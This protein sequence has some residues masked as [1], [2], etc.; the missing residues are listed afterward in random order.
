[1]DILSYINRINQLYGSES[2]VASGKG[3]GSVIP[4]EFDE[5]SPREEQYYQQGPFS[6]RED[7]LAAKGGS[8]Y[9]TRKYFKPGGLVEP[10]V[11]HYG[12]LVQ[13]GPGRQGYNGVKP[14]DISRPQNKPALMSDDL[15]TWYEKN[16]GKILKDA[17]GN[18]KPARAW[19]DL[20][21]NERMSVKS[22]F[23]KRNRPFYVNLRK[24][25]TLKD[26]LQEQKDAGRTVF[27]KTLPEIAKEA[28]LTLKGHQVRNIIK[29]YFPDTFN[30]KG[31][32]LDQAP[33]VLKRVKELAKTDTA[34]EITNILFDEG[35]AVSKN[36]VSVRQLMKDNKI[37][38][39]T[40][41]Q[42]IDDL[43]KTYVKNNPKITD[44]NEIAENLS[45]QVGK[46]I[47][48]TTV[49]LA[50]KRQNIKNLTS[51]QEVI[52]KEV[53]VLDN[54][55][56]NSL[57][58]INDPNMTPTA[59]NSI[60]QQ[61]YLKATGKK[62][63]DL[64]S[65]EFG[66]RLSRL[67]KLYAGEGR[68][69]AFKNIKSPLNYLDLS[70]PLQKN[71]I[72]MASKAKWM[73]NFTM[74]QMLGLPKNQLKLIADTQKMMGA[75]DFSVAGD[76]TDI[77]SMMKDFPKYKENFS[78]IEYIKNNLNLY[79]KK[80][81]LQINALRKKAQEATK[82][83]QLV[84]AQKFLDDAKI[85]QE[86]FA[87]NTGY[88]IGTFDIKNN[89]VVINPQTARL[90]DLKNPRNTALQ[91]AMENFA[92]TS[93]PIIGKIGAATK[94]IFSPIDKKF[95]SAN[96]EE[97][98]ELLKYANKNPE[99]A[100]QSQYLKALSKIPGKYGKI[101]RTILKGTGVVA[102]TM[103]MATLASAGTTKEKGITTEEMKARKEDMTEASMVPKIISENPWKSAGVATG[104]ALTQKPV[105]SLL[106]K[107]MTKTLSAL[108]WVFETKSPAGGAFWAAEAP[109]LMLQGAYGRYANER[110]FKAG[111]K[112]AGL[113]D[114][115]IEKLGE[116][117]GQELADMGQVG[118][119]SWAVDQ[120]DTFETR[121]KITEEMA[122]K[123][124]HFET[125]QAGPLMMKDF[126]AIKTGERK[127]QD[128]EEQL[129]QYEIEKRTREAYERQ[130]GRSTGGRV[131]FVKGKLVDKGRR[132]FMKWLAGITGATVAAGTGLIK[133]G[134]FAG[135]GKTV[136]K[137]GDHIIQGTPGMPDW[138]IPLIN[139]ITKEGDDVSKKLATVEREIVHTK[140]IGAKGAFEGDEVTV[141]QNLDTGN[142]R[143]EYGPPL[144]D[145]KGNVIRATN[146]QEVVHLEYK[147]GEV[148][149]E[150][151]YRGT[152][153]DP[154]FSA[155]ESEP[156][157]TRTGPDD[158]DLTFEG[159]N[160]VNKVEDLT[161]D[162][163]PLKQFGTKKKLTH[164]DKVVAKKK[165]KYRQQLEEDTSTQA[166]YIETKYGPGPEPDTSIDEFGNVIDEYGEIIE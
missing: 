102:G 4:E 150:G 15:S 87:T 93:S 130:I 89:R 111:L 34:N 60:L 42:D 149:E 65:G 154:E 54:I 143:V 96:V 57:G 39:K 132:A 68:I 64:S 148:I 13:S 58:I 1:M 103:G 100:K 163:S 31:L 59:K 76:H 140:K 108:K 37:P 45:D 117:Y 164:K 152:K 155:A 12:Q 99:I 138:F 19:E 80:Y 3:I 72:E 136:I 51:L 20:K 66:S 30:Y 35:L 97:R 115:A 144:L 26:F 52:L 161:T 74:G 131:P 118:L 9:N 2:Q 107:P 116:V 27:K 86:N 85:I 78:R 50:A 41:T 75:F 77:Q 22:Q 159:I 25:E 112:R 141:Y 48:P 8:V 61:R 113:P 121:K 156:N 162:V 17:K 127:I 46:N 33:G 7:F 125:R 133:W 24:L 110:D 29:N 147:A 73:D 105:R 128:Y 71:I 137:A 62:F 91:T 56:T 21:I 18:F 129:K 134:K 28:G 98:L 70:N 36:D 43:V 114:E 81:D 79:K 16:K 83:G 151:K 101:A 84:K 139:R 158:A 40:A 145:K 14:G 5:L 126:G 6:T 165:Q 90:P 153:T 44:I 88:R 135:K 53:K 120:P 157:Y 82:K 104:A 124:P 95:M 23:A 119:E 92:K 63:A 55:V 122:E 106:K 11:T 47:D 160:E 146:D 38:I 166:D 67:A 123:K 94:E 10:G 49:R 142:V 109:I 69:K 32:D